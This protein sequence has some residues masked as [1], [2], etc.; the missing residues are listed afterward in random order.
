MW[1]DITT[2]NNGTGV[3]ITGDSSSISLAG[4]MLVKDDTT[5]MEIIGDNNSITPA[6]YD[7][8][9]FG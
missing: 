5:G 9:I 4:S 2:T 7:L 3:K 6:T 8:N 1:G